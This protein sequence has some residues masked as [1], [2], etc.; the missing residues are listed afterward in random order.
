MTVS[1]EAV[2]CT[3]CSYLPVLTSSGGKATSQSSLKIMLFSSAYFDIVLFFSFPIYCRHILKILN[4]F[5][6]LVL[7]MYVF[8]VLVS[9]KSEV[10]EHTNHNSTNELHCPPYIGIHFLFNLKRCM[11]YISASLFLEVSFLSILWI[12]SDSIQWIF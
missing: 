1:S 8:I 6:K 9:D 3:N 5:L 11:S 2:C 7:F 10:F 12:I 4:Y